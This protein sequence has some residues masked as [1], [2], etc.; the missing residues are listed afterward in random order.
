M[1]VPNQLTVARIVLSIVMFVLLPLGWYK[2]SFALFVITAGTDHEVV[3]AQ[4]IHKLDAVRSHD[5][6]I[7]ACPANNRHIQPQFQLRLNPLQL[8]RE[9]YSI[10]WR[11][12]SSNPIAGYEAITRQH[13]NQRELNLSRQEGRKYKKARSEDRAF[14]YQ[15]TAPTHHKARRGILIR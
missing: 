10:C 11:D 9:I 6:I 7:T 2:T 14:D 4:R 1:N 3:A 12:V 13:Q 8:V 5:E 15:P